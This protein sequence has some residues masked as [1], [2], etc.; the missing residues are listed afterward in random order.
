MKEQLKVT[1]TEL[2]LTKRRLETLEK[3]EKMMGKMSVTHCRSFS[4]SQLREDDEESKME[5]YKTQQLME[6]WLRL[7][8]S[9]I[10]F[11]TFEL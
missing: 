3:K 9:I 1:E 7:S 2:D 8:I 6:R 4:A 11:N 5:K 10:S